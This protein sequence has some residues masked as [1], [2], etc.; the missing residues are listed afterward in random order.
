MKKCHCLSLKRFK[1][2]LTREYETE[3]EKASYKKFESEVLNTKS[4]CTL[5]FQLLHILCLLASSEASVIVAKEVLDNGGTVKF[6]EKV[7][8]ALFPVGYC[9]MIFSIV[10]RVILLPLSFKWPKICKAFLSFEL[11]CLTLDSFLI[12]DINFKAEGTIQLLSS[13]LLFF[14]LQYDLKSS[15]LAALIAQITVMCT[16]YYMFELT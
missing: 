8:H 11:L 1:A 4:R 14:T 6:N 7:A 12:K 5:V 2:T 16:Q 15:C 13:M 3:Q 9:G 10:G